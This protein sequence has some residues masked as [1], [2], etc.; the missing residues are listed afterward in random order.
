M[1]RLRI[2]MAEDSEGARNRAASWH[3]SVFCSDEGWLPW[4]GG[5]AS[6]RPN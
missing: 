5:A 2:F 1:P 6:L 4:C 3:A